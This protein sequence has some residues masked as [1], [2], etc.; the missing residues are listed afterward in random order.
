MPTSTTFDTGKITRIMIYPNQPEQVTEDETT[1]TKYRPAR[2][3][4][5]FDITDGEITKRVKRL[6]TLGNLNDAPL[7][8]K[9]QHAALA[10]IGGAL[11]DIVKEAVQEGL[12]E[13]VTA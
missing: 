10:S 8:L 1:V 4:I 3:E 6:A 2:A 5:H 9:Q 13:D 11:Q 7:T 12:D